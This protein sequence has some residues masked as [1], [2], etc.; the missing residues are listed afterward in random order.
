M[1]SAMLQ[2]MEENFDSTGEDLIKVATRCGRYLGAALAPAYLFRPYRVD[3]N[4]FVHCLFM[5]GVGVST[6][7][8]S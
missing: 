8:Q 7:R 6:Y 4:L 1:L 5:C 3:L 2:Q